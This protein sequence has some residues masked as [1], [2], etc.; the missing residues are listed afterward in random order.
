MVYTE[1]CEELMTLLMA[2][3]TSS[4]QQKSLPEAWKLASVSLFFTKGSKK[5]P[6]NYHPVS[7]TAI[8]FKIM[9]SFIRDHILSHMT[10][11]SLLSKKQFG[12]LK[13]R[14][15]VLQLLRILDKWVQPQDDGRNVDTIYMDFQ[16][17]FNKVPH[18]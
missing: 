11:N 13:G 12:F 17:L 14:S 18:K 8:V 10:R 15:T 1:L 7:L 4:F 9:G 16:K 5:L 2:I 3:Y 6:S